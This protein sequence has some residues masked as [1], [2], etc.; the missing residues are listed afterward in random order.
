MYAIPNKRKG[1]LSHLREN[2]AVGSCFFSPGPPLTPSWLNKNTQ[3]E[4]SEPGSR[5]R[6]KEEKIKSAYNELVMT[7]HRKWLVLQIS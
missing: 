6:A 2:L 7:L 4:F 5:R 3:V 1:L